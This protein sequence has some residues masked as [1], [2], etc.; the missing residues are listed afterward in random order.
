M[1]VLNSIPVCQNNLQILS[2][3]FFVEKFPKYSRQFIKNDLDNVPNIY[4]YIYANKHIL[5][6]IVI[7]TLK[8]M[9]HMI[10][11]TNGGTQRTDQLTNAL[12]D[13]TRD[14]WAWK[15]VLKSVIFYFKTTLFKTPVLKSKTKVKVLQLNSKT[16]RKTDYKTWQTV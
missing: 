9:K 6:R 4:I 8:N 14:T 13:V 10:K 3:R 1:E 15:L 16:E 7:K 5:L 2:V 12:C 11:N